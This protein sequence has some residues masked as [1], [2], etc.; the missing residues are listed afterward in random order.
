MANLTAPISSL[1]LASLQ[2][3]GHALGLLRLSLRLVFGTNDPGGS[4]LFMR[5]LVYSQFLHFIF[6]TTV[7][8][9][10]IVFGVRR[11]PRGDTFLRR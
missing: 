6:I 4:S 2:V 1:I 9:V 11:P 3:L 10:L 8:C 7:L 5:V